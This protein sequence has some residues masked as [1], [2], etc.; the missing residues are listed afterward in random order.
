MDSAGCVW[1]LEGEMSNV[2]HPQHYNQ[3]PAGIE[4]I[5]VIEEF[6]FNIGS[7]MK[8]LWRYELKDAPVE[9]LEKAVWYIQREIERRKKRD[10]NER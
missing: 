9:D 7:A 5:D 4:C 8:Y 6:G 1:F 10:G 3:H 2:N